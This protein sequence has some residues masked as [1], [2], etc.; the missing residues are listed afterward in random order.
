MSAPDDLE[1]IKAEIGVI[2]QQLTDLQSQLAGI[3]P[4]DWQAYIKVR[5]LLGTTT[6][7]LEL[8]NDGLEAAASDA[9]GGTV[10]HFAFVHKCAMVGLFEPEPGSDSS[11][12]YDP[13]AVQR[14]ADLGG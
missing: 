4:D 13:S 10:S 2:Q 7:G 11:G 8:V 6:G 9:A 14:F 5:K 3:S 12:A 1:A